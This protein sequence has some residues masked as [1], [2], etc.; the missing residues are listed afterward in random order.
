MDEALAKGKTGSD[1]IDF[2][3]GVSL[4]RPL[5]LTASSPRKTVVPRGE[6]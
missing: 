2:R 6:A 5:F 3:R 1:G 4:I